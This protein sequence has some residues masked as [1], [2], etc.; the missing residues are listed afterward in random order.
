[1]SNEYSDHSTVSSPPSP[2]ADPPGPAAAVTLAGLSDSEGAAI[3]ALLSASLVAQSNEAVAPAPQCEPAWANAWTQAQA[4]VPLF[5][6]KSSPFQSPSPTPP[7]QPVQHFGPYGH[8]GH[9]D[10]HAD[11]CM[12]P[13][14]DHRADGIT[15][16]KPVPANG[17][18]YPAPVL[19][20]RPYPNAANRGVSRDGLYAVEGYHLSSYATLPG[21]AVVSASSSK[22]A[23]K[24]G[25]KRARYD[26]DF[27]EQ[28]VREAMRCPEGARIKPTCSRYPGVEPCQLRKWIQKFAPLIQA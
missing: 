19:G 28:V 13:R 17:G 21:G 27:K 16:A 25:T 5:G 14:F 15:R 18:G 26:D 8:Y 3:R 24:A 7:P 22:K 23:S 12:D 2:K 1:M 10:P 11:Y 20:K 9:W 4:S 6:P